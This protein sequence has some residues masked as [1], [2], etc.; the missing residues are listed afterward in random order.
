MKYTIIALIFMMCGCATSHKYWYEHPGILLGGV[1][2]GIL[3][4]PE[5]VAIRE[6]ERR[7]IKNETLIYS[8]E[9]IP[10]YIV[11]SVLHLGTAIPLL[12]SFPPIGLGYLGLS[13][14]VGS[15]QF[16]RLN[17]LDG[18]VVK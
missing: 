13:S 17:A 10:T 7:A 2:Y 9:F 16:Y 12:I 3:V 4:G 8:S 6:A 18:D 14:L 5:N 1:G 15:A 11:G